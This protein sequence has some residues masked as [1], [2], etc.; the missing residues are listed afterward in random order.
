M[1][2]EKR[3]VNRVLNKKKENLEKRNSKSRKKTNKRRR[4]YTNLA[5]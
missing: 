1:D 5:N 3:N 4:S 2:N